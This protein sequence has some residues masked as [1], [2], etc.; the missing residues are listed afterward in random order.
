MRYIPKTRYMDITCFVYLFHDEWIL[1]HSL[2]HE[3]IT[4]GAVEAVQALCQ[5]RR[6]KAVPVVPEPRRRLSLMRAC[7]HR[8]AVPLHSRMAT[9]S[10]V[11]SSTR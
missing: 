11:R 5:P 2:I 10:L 6:P 3:C 1:D 8:V 4:R 9:T 7:R